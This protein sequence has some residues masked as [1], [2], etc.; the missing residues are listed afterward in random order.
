MAENS[1]F[2]TELILINV[3]FLLLMLCNSLIMN[4]IDHSRNLKCTGTFLNDFNVSSVD[5]TVRKM[6]NSKC[7]HKGKDI[8]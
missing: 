2:S 7:S 5:D 1:D 4:N 6:I 3:V 8:V